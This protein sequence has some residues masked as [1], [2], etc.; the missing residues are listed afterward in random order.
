MTNTVIDE[1]N[2]ELDELESKDTLKKDGMKTYQVLWRIM[3]YRPRLYIA[4]LT[5]VF[6]IYMV[7]QIPGLVSREIFDHLSAGAGVGFNLWTMLALLVFAALGEMGGVY[8]IIRSNVPLR[9]ILHTLLQRNLMQRIL[10]RPGAKSLPESPG[11]AINRI[12]NDVNELPEYL[13]WTNDVIG[14][15]IYAAIALTIMVSINLK[16]TLIAVGPMLL[17]VFLASAFTE[18]VERYRKETRETSGKVI[19]FIAETFGAA[20]AIKVAGAEDK[21]INYFDILNERR[22]KAALKDRLFQELL[23][24]IFW[25][26]GN[27]GTGI[28]LILAGQA[29]QDK[30]FTVGDF[31]LFV[32][33][34]AFIAEFTGLLGI[35][36]ARYKQAGVS[37]NRLQRL[38]Q[39]APEA[40]LVEYGPVYER[41]EL[42]TVPF[43]PRT[44]EHRLETLEVK[45]LR[46]IHPKSGH[47]IESVD[48]TLKRGS[49][50]VITGRIGSGKTTL[51]RSLLGLLPRDEGEIRWNG[52]LVEEPGDFFVPPRSA[53]TGQVPRLFSLSLRDNL[54]MGL[55]ENEVDIEGSISKA[56]MEKDL[57]DLEKGL[58]TQVGPKG[59]R[60]SGGQMQ[61]SAAARMFVR[62][63]ELLV[64]DDLSSA[65]DVETESKL[66][67]R[68]FDQQD[69][70]CLVVSHRHT[71]L[72]RAD[73][74]IV[75][76]DGRIDAEGSLNDLLTTCEEMQRLWHGDLVSAE[77]EAL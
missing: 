50:T 60:L 74:I 70:T 69:V 19:G 27:I 42:P 68:V 40:Q 34:L 21:V 14:S 20:Q 35:V 28:I 72:R 18:Q 45:G 61:R 1:L 17:V 29:I 3:R 37:V 12:K 10:Q 77:A 15:T 5:S 36:L 8:G 76:K 9:F 57:A 66:W 73:H 55:P 24:S 13:L 43:T 63:P 51:L 75:L 11:E 52:Q 6:L 44:A 65:L 54:L 41:G 58:D 16:I 31:A 30:T 53:Y 49:F 4:N 71:A 46:Y 33:N 56:V 62:N 67:E 22:R 48:L 39:G 47:G 23:H 32:Y 26:A 2:D 38:M 64:F 7:L 25:N 59:V